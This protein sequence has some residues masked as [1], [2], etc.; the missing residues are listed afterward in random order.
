MRGRSPPTVVRVNKFFQRFV[1]VAG[2]AIFATVVIGFLAGQFGWL[3]VRATDGQDGAYKQITVY[4]D[5]LEHIQSDYV[6]EP[7]MNKV[8]TGA[9]HG[10]LES[11]DPDSSYLSPAEYK[12][13]KDNEP[14][15]GNGV[16]L[17]V[18]KRYGYAVIVTILPGSPA[19]KEH[20]SDGDIIESIDNQSTRDLSIAMIRTLLCGK[21]GTTVTISVVRQM[22]PEGDK[23]TLTR[24]P[25]AAP[26]LDEKQISDVNALYL[27]PGELTEASID[28]LTQKI[29]ADGKGKSLILDLR[30]N[31]VG[32]ESEG[33]RLAN[34]FIN[35]GTLATLN[36]QKFP[37]QT[38]TADATKTITD[39]PLIVLVNR[40]TFGA[41][42]L[43]ADAIIDAKRGDVL[44]EHTFGEGSVQKTFELP[45]GAALFLTVAKYT[46]PAGHKIEDDAVTPTMLVGINEDDSFAAP[47]PNK[48]D[49]IFAKAVELLKARAAAPPTATA[50]VKN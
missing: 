49:E 3:G 6:T 35:Q 43:A 8:T 37:T 28:A 47:N 30:D 17:V 24:G 26:A 20:L 1:L 5:V 12:I 39:A 7:N 25:V 32:D 48:T 34:L 11:L 21:P 45:D 41:S 36:G 29:K 40:G 2:A 27:K 38:F 18:T 46:S 31:A 15:V 10:L 23:I 14:N 9:L 4:D 33:I 22:K 16:G 50:P 19:A 13:Y 42:E 44:G